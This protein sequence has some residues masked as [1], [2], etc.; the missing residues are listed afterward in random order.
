MG[1]DNGRDDSDD[2]W[3]GMDNDDNDDYDIGFCSGMDGNCDTDIV[4]RMNDIIVLVLVVARMVMVILMFI[5]WRIVVILVLLVR[6]THG[7]R[8]VSSDNNGHIG[9]TNDDGD[10]AVDYGMDSGGHIGIWNDWLVGWLVVYS[11]V[12]KMW[13]VKNSSISNNSV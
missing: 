7:I 3:S 12:Y 9:V 5:I 2:I 1:N 10:I 8:S 13:N 11:F 4:E 6:D